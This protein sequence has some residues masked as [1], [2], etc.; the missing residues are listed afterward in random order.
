MTV[1]DLIVY[2]KYE[3]K[4]AELLLDMREEEVAQTIRRDFTFMKLPHPPRANI[5]KPTLKGVTASWI[6]R[7]NSVS[8]TPLT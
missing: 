8:N 5:R 6:T 4:K 7:K 3:P 1:L 2:V